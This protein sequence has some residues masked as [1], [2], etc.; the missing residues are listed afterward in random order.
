MVAAAR[1]ELRAYQ[2][3]DR[4]QL[5]RLLAVGR[6]TGYD[7]RKR[8]IFEWQFQRNP[9][10]MR[11]SPFVV[12]ESNGEVVGMSGLMPARVRFQGVSRAA[13]WSCDTYVSPQSRGRGFGKQLVR[14]VSEAAPV[15][16]AFGISHMSDPI[17]HSF[18][19][20]LHPRVQL[21]FFHVAER[22]VKGAIKNCLTR[23][24]SL[25]TFN[26]AAVD[27]ELVDEWG[28]ALGGELDT[29][30]AECADG[31][32]N[33]VERDGAYLGW[34]YFGHPVLHYRGYALRHAGALRG[35]MIARYHPDESVI[36]DYCG[37][38]NDR[39]TMLDL[40]TST[41]RDLVA[42]GT[43]RVRCETTHPP[44]LAALREVGFVG[45]SY[46]SRFRVHAR[47]AADA[48]GDWLVMTGDSD[49]DMLAR[50]AAR[51]S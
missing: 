17:F 20:R 14:H 13:C 19:W 36:A 31:Y 11:C 40:V 24:A 26:R 2:P 18:G 23:L 38:A 44:L 51:A 6:P 3:S 10:C 42:R 4:E 1:L 50:P 33:A 7:A 16:L 21:V 45:S 37:P 22:G 47:D 9:D 39:D 28:D 49:G 25:R 5:I 27:V 32:V 41:L 12:G 15:M 34:K 29:L 46:A 43:A 35:L 8:A 48:V 30:W